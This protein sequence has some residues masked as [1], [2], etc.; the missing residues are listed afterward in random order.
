MSSFDRIPYITELSAKN[1]E[2]LTYFTEQ[3]GDIPNLYAVMMYSKNALN[4]YYQFH[5]REMSLTKKECE[6]IMLVVSEINKSPYCLSE[7]TMIGKL[8]G[9]SDEEIVQLRKGYAAFDDKLNALV[10]FIK[11]TISNVQNDINLL[12]ACFEAGYSHENIIDALQVTG[13][14]YMSN[15]TSKIL[16]VPVDFPLAVEI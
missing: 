11:N 5:T 12:D 1:M 16:K 8:N 6:A 13:D 3:L 14:A 15:F 2:Y 10:S 9:F 7:H 4:A